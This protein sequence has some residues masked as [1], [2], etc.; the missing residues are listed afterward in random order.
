MGNIH[1]RILLALILL[2]GSC[3]LPVFAQGA[4]TATPANITVA[5]TKMD[6][7]TRTIILAAQED[8]T[9]L[10]FYPLDLQ[11]G[12]GT[13]FPAELIQ[14]TRIS[15][16]IANGSVQSVQVLFELRDAPDTGSFAGEMWFSYAG[17]VAKVPVTVMVKAGWFWPLVLLILAV[18]VSYSLFV[19]KSKLKRKD[20]IEVRIGI[21]ERNIKKDGKLKPDSIYHYDKGVTRENPFYPALQNGIGTVRDKLKADLIEDAEKF[22]GN[23]EKIW[24][25]WSYNPSEWVHGLDTFSRCIRDIETNEEQILGT[26]K[27]P[28]GPVK[29][30]GEIPY[31]RDIR[32]EL[33]KAFKTLTEYEKPNE[34]TDAVIEQGARARTYIDHY[35]RILAIQ[36]LCDRCR[37]QHPEC[38]LDTL[39]ASYLDHP[40]KGSFDQLVVEIAGRKK[41]VEEKCPPLKMPFGAEVPPSIFTVPG[42]YLGPAGVPRSTSQAWLHLRIF[43]AGSFLVTLVILVTIGYS[44][45][46]LA[47]PTFGSFADYATLAL[48]GLLAGPFADKLGEKTGQALFKIE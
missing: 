43:A 3:V 13:I 12:E 9:D 41:V 24:D 39:W 4:L 17:G 18:L 6:M 48:W 22:L 16:Q 40:P 26:E 7:P 45:L 44:E 19:Y 1:L 23:T 35:Y 14:A 28:D 21:I 8:I 11:S 20:E 37:E 25:K 47:K 32:A 36:R 10:K 27:I 31:L 5:G 38:D 34:F 15:S 2:A 46:Y 42:E 33:Q 29:A 30:S